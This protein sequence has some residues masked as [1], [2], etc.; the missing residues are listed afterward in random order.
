MATKKATKACGKGGKCAAKG[1]K[2]AAKACG[3]GGKSC[4]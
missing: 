2:T 4:K 1:G 3:K